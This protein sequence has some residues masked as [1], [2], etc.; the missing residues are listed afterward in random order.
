[1]SCPLLPDLLCAHDNICI[2]SRI[3]AH[4]CMYVCVLACMR[5][6]M[7]V[8]ACYLWHLSLLGDSSP[9][10]VHGG[11]TGQCNGELVWL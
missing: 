9:A 7:C 6:C 1:M 4:V 3:S 11:G 5:T 10:G 8:Y 2:A